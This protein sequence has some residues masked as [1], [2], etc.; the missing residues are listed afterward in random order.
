MKVRT[1]IAPSPTGFFHFGSARTALFNY[2]FTRQAGGNFIL[3]VED[4][5]A[6]RNEK[7]FEDDIHN[8][9]SWLGLEADEVYK[10]SELVNT[11][12]DAIQELIKK[13]AAYVSRESAKDDSGK[14]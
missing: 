8:Q 5:D 11:H 13:G 12:C 9:L 3:R 6:A 4:T 1:R 7:R 14:E 2:L 10:Q